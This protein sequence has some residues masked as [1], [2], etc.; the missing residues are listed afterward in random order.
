VFVGA[1]T[2][3]GARPDV[4]AEYGDRFAKS[5][6]GLTVQALPAGTYDI[7]VFAYST[8]QRGFV[9]AQVVRVT[10]K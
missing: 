8:V 9:P 5:G 3:G 4:A 1:A 6:Y 7:A 2:Y 10:I